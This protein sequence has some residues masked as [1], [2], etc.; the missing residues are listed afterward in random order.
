MKPFPH[1]RMLAFVLGCASSYGQVAPASTEMPA[2]NA[3]VEETVVLS[4]FQVQGARSDGY[5]VPEAMGASRVALPV[6]DVP[7]SVIA[8]SEQLFADKAAVNAI[9]VLSLVSGVTHTASLSPRFE[10]YTLRGFNIGAGIGFGIRDGLPDV[11]GTVVGAVDDTSGYER[12][13]VIKGPAGTLYGTSSMGGVVNKISKWPKFTRQTKVQLQAQTYDEFIRAMVDSTGP[14]G[15][16]GAYRAVIAQQEGTRYWGSGRNDSLNVVLAYTHLLGDSRAGGRLWGRFQ[17]FSHDLA[18][19]NGTLFPTGWKDP[20]NPNFAPT[21][22]NPRFAVPRTIRNVPDDDNA[23]GTSRAYEAGFD[24]TWAQ[25][26]DNKWTIRLVARHNEALGDQGPSYSLTLPV[27][28]NSAG[29]I[30]QYTR[31]PRGSW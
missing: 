14:V 9:E 8:L 13:E 28:V 22:D 2:R 25:N 11:I 4:P 16:R 26:Q 17:Y 7:L 29:Q 30:V 12:V 1:P 15:N 19:V 23:P 6:S 31:M 21:L 10:S 24:Y 20:L 3:T 5:S 27:P 18:I